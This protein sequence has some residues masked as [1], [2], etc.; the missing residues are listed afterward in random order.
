LIDSL[1]VSS[2]LHHHPPTEMQAWGRA[3]Y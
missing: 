2:W 1:D 3:T